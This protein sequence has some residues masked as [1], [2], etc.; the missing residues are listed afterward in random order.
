[1]AISNNSKN[2]FI[3]AVSDKDVANEILNAI[4]VGPHAQAA[5]IAAIVSADIVPAAIVPA[6]IPDCSA[7]DVDTAIAAL[8]VLV[9]ARLDA[10]EAKQN[11]V[12]AALKAAGL[13]L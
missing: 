6:G 10:I 7:A 3:Q 13:M 5:S 1:M 4:L 12:I 9:E 8:V 11:A 2:W